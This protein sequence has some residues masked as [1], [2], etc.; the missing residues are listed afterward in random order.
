MLNV[1][2]SM[3]KSAP[4]NVFDLSDFRERIRLFR[5]RE[6]AGE[7]LAGMLPEPVTQGALVLG[8]PAG[9]VPVAA[10]ISKI[11]RIDLDIAVVSKITLPWNTEVGYGAIA[12]DGTVQLNTALLSQTGLTQADVEAGIVATRSKVERRVEL[13]RKGRHPMD[14][15]GRRVILVDDG[16]ASGITLQ[17]AVTAVTGLG[18]GDVQVAVPTG[19]ASS[20]RKLAASVHA[21][22]CANIRTGARFAVANAY[23]H[24][25][26]VDEAT[27]LRLMDFAGTP[28]RD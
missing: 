5:D 17:V 1:R 27:V 16:L 10:V 28:R 4:S 22:Y 25:T 21:V 24:W 2:A 7:I 18:A 14:L 19:H 15:A 11:R 9:G 8:I 6:H 3:M 12:F 26:D 23:E 20:V 13:L